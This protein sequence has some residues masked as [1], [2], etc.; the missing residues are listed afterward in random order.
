MYV[1]LAFALTPWGR[2]GDRGSAGKALE[3]GRHARVLRPRR[4]GGNARRPKVQAPL[5]EAAAGTHGPSDPRRPRLAVP[6]ARAGGPCPPALE[7]RLRPESAGRAGTLTLM[8]WWSLLH[9]DV[10]GVEPYVFVVLPNPYEKRHVR[11]GWSNE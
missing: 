1:L 9:A 10:W 8:R 3:A 6:A 7:E 11:N 5:S 2:G 4:R